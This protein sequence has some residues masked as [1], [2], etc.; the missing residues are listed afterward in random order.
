MHDG[1]HRTHVAVA[2]GA[3]DV[4]PHVHSVGEVDEVRDRE[5]PLPTEGLTGLDVCRERLDS[6]LLLVDE[7]VAA[8]ALAARRQPGDR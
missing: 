7:L 4:R 8:H 3:S 1:L 6:G 2:L 5:D